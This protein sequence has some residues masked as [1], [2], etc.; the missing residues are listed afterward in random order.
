MVQGL[1][2]DDTGSGTSAGA[3][4]TFNWTRPMLGTTGTTQEYKS[5]AFVGAT[6]QLAASTMVFNDGPRPRPICD[7]TASGVPPRLCG[8]GSI[9][10]GRSPARTWFEAMGQ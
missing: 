2:K 5:A 10:G 1:S 8:G 4:R 6:P 7:S 9:Y 3:L